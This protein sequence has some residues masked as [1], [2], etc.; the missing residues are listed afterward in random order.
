MAN[1]RNKYIFWNLIFFYFA[2]KWLGGIFWCLLNLVDYFAILLS[3][4]LTFVIQ[5]SNKPNHLCICKKCE[6]NSPLPDV[7]GANSFRI[8]YAF[9]TAL[10]L[11]YLR[12]HVIKIVYAIASMRGYGPVDHI[13][14]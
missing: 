8:W 12:F 1:L 13:E 2:T 9:M 10:P 3:S 5:C 14:C 4:K 11:K 6:K 7:A